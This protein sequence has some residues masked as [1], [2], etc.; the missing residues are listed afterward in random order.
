MMSAK[1]IAKISTAGQNKSPPRQ[2]PRMTA[3][4]TGSVQLKK[5]VARVA[6][7]DLDE[8]TSGVLRDC[9]KQFG[10]Q[11]VGFSDDAIHRLQKEKFEGL[12]LRLDDKAGAVLESARNSPS[13]RRIVIYGIASDPKQALKYSR[14][15]VNA[16]V[17][18]RVERQA[19]L[20]V[21]RATHLLVLHELRRYVRIPVVSEVVLLANK[22]RIAAHSVEISGGGMSVRVGTKLSIGHTMDICFDLPKKPGITV[23]GVV[24]WVRE[25]DGMAGL[26]FNPEDERHLHVKDWINDYL[27]IS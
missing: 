21:V 11:T 18:E 2:T 13:N 3:T 1:E 23:T 24:C 4:A 20:K 27:E 7:I 19:A 26:R 22:R 25:M 6:L 8:A 15:G 17:D 12:V 9:F 10:I 16:V 14:F 5:A